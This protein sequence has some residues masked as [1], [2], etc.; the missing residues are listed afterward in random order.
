MLATPVAELFQFDLTLD[1]IDLDRYLPPAAPAPVAAS[2]SKQAATVP[3]K[4]VE[5]PLSA[6]RALAVQGKFRVLQLKAMRLRSNDALVQITA[7]NGLI[8]LGPNQAMMYGGRYQGT[9]GIDARGKVLLL[10]MNEA[11]DGVQIQDLLKDSKIL[12][13]FPLGFTGTTKFGAKLTAQGLDA[14]QVVQTLS[15][16]VELNIAD[17][18]MSGVDLKKMEE[19]ISAAFKEKS[20]KNLS[21]LIPK[22]EDK[23][24]FT[25]LRGSAKIDKG[26]VRND[27]LKI[28]SPKLVRVNGKGTVDL[29]QENLNYVVTVGTFPIKI[30]GNFAKLKYRPDRDTILGAAVEQ[31]KTE[32]REKA[33]EK[34]QEKI[35]EKYK[36]TL[37]NLLR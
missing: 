23:T 12:A 22:P 8:T 18:F 15:G 20:L 11:L 34:V 28:E 31:V 25:H 10:S 24:T 30:S 7:D 4:P 6:L 3:A 37:R 26:M 27:D 2:G 36:D 16:N 9:T 1:Q 21:E 29:S 5:I 33:K 19:T 14:K 17:G 35:P 13:N 32:A